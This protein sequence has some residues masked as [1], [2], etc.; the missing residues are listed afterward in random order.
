MPFTVIATR[1]TTSRER[2]LIASCMLEVAPC[3][4]VAPAMSARTRDRLWSLLGKWHRSGA[5]G[6]IV[7]V[8]SD[9]EAGLKV[10][11]LGP[12]PVEIVD[13]DGL[14]VAMRPC[15]DG[16][17]DADGEDRSRRSGDGRRRGRSALRTPQ[18]A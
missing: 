16:V 10:A 4:Y 7:M 11:K 5:G 2:G 14:L 12:M 3:T 9:R 6:G 18:G 15:R 1:D 17:T 8:W 13:W